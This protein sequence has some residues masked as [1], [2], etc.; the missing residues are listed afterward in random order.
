MMMKTLTHTPTALW[1]GLRYALAK[2]LA[3][4]CAVV[5]RKARQWSAYAPAATTRTDPIW[6]FHAEAG[7]PEGALFVNGELVGHVQVRRL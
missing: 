1:P 7:A 4:A 6:E 5:W 3:R 2:A